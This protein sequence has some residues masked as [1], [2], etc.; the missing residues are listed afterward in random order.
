M[1]MGKQRHSSPRE[2][3]DQASEVVS[4]GHSNDLD[5]PA[6][7]G[8]DVPLL[9][10]LHEDLTYWA[11]HDLVK[12]YGNLVRIW[13][14]YDRDCPSN[15]CYVVFATAAEAMSGSTSRVF[16]QRNVTGSDLD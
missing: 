14:A 12:P 4:F 16:M 6:A 8:R 3:V 1:Y 7:G 5:S 10:D 11:I 2:V 9:H 15:M 13:L